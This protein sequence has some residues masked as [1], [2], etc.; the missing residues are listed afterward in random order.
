MSIVLSEHIG[1]MTKKVLDKHDG[2]IEEEHIQTKQGCAVINEKFTVKFLNINRNLLYEASGDSIVKAYQ[3]LENK[4]A[5]KYHFEERSQYPYKI[6]K[7]EI[8]NIT[9]CEFEN[10][11]GKRNQTFN[12]FDC[13]LE[14]E[15][16]VIQ[17]HNAANPIIIFKCLQNSPVVNM[18][19][20][21]VDC[22]RGRFNGVSYIKM[23]EAV[24]SYLGTDL[25]VRAN[26]MEGYR[27]RK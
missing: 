1:S 12:G 21:N 6:L 18:N 11:E 19:I 4:I 27:W 16:V 9:A 3:R 13:R 15:S 10:K 20:L 22:F 8:E 23:I 14:G 25:S 5:N 26:E 24:K 7:S 17:V 2:T